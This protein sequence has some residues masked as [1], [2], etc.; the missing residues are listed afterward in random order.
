MLQYIHISAS[1][2]MA[3]LS[4]AGERGLMVMTRAIRVF[5]ENLI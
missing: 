4:E 5:G 1:P 2:M 3:I